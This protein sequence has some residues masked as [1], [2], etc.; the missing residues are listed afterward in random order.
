VFVYD[1][2]TRQTERVSVGDGGSQLNGPSSAPAI[3]GDGRYVA[4]ESLASNLPQQGGPDGGS[5]DVF[6]RDRETGTTE[7]VSVALGGAKDDGESKEPSISNDGK[8]VAF[9][10]KAT[11]LVAGDTAPHKTDV[12]VRDL[13]QGSTKRV[14]VTS[15]GG[16]ADDHSGDDYL[17]E[18]P[19]AI[20]ADGRFGAFVSLATNILGDSNET[21]DTDGLFDVFVHDRAA[22]TNVTR[23]ASA[24]NG[25]E[26][27]HAYRPTISAD[28]LVVAFDSRLPGSPP[29]VFL[30]LRDR[31]GDG[32]GD[33]EDNC[34]DVPNSGQEDTDG[35]GLGD[36]CDPDDDN[37]GVP[38]ASDNCP[39]ASNSDQLD[40]DGDGT[41]DA[42]D[43]SPQGPAGLI[44]DLK[45]RTYKMLDLPENCADSSGNPCELWPSLSGTLD[46]ALR[47]LAKGN[48][49][50]ACA[51][52]RDYQ[53]AVKTSEGAFTWDEMEE[54]I[55]RSEV[56]RGELG[57]P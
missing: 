49:A 20:S 29:Y 47:H 25:F 16:Q 19:P 6:V 33:V 4:F 48:V 41:G 44:E 18:S 43:S 15:T 8:F 3:S 53:W 50:G 7:H 5:A 11:N 14:S 26:F 9:W 54:L 10:S 23:L 2:E 34:A 35:D 37:D 52:L 51:D 21:R 12:F 13:S 31:D 40:S 45:W 24:G 1:R 30:S 56:I 39:T 36:A 27:N 55:G 38:D 46:S 22:N 28:G 57:C 42:C 17:V 32:K